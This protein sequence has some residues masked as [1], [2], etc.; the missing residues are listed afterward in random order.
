MKHLPSGM[1]QQGN[2]VIHRLDATIKMILLIILF[3]AVITA[4]TIIGYALIIAFTA[5]I[6]IISQIG[7][8]AAFGSIRRMIWFF[9]IVFLMNI[10]FYQTENT[11]FSF[12]IFNPSYDGFM[13][14]VTVVVRVA[15]FLVLCNVLNSSTPPVEI[16]NAIENIISPLK[17]IKVPTHQIALILSVAIQF[18]PTLFEEADMIYKA[19]LARG[20][21]FD[22]RSLIDKAKAV[23]PMI[24][25]IFVS[26]FRRADE[27]SLAMEARGYR[28]DVDS[29]KKRS[30][31]FS[32][33]ELLA[34]IVCAALCI[35]QIT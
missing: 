13:Q 2:S 20:A 19:Q 15:V 33:S 23:L 1:Y 9:I 4:D 28:V 21:R 18:V 22:S 29:I 8:N 3:A 32:V 35:I 6:A 31:H 27:L 14:G 5:I 16:T 24:V 30:V 26:A 12:W 34:L 11:W 10:C 17:F 25:P 7:I